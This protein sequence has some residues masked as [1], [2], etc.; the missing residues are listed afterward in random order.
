TGSLPDTADPERDPERLSRLLCG[1]RHLA[2]QFYGLPF[3]EVRDLADELYA[4]AGTAAP[5]SPAGAKA[6]AAATDIYELTMPARM[7]RPGSIWPLG[8]LAEFDG[9]AGSRGISREAAVAWLT[10]G[11]LASLRQ[12]AD[13]QGLDFGAAMAAAIREHAQQCLSAHGPAGTGLAPGRRPVPVLA[14]PPAA[15]PF[16]PAATHQGVVTAPGDAEWLLIRTTA[17][18]EHARQHGYRASDRDADDRIALTEALARACG[19][20]EADVTGRLAPGVAARVTE[21]EHGPAD[22]ARLGREHGQAG[23]VPYCDLDIDGD[24]AAL[25][26]ALGETEQMTDANHGYRISLVIAYADA[27][28]QAS[29]PAPPAAGS[30][31]RDAARG[32]PPPSTSPRSGTR[33]SP[34]AAG[35]ATAHPLHGPERRHGRST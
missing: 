19:L 34:A 4:R 10:A 26:D 20:P 1:V 16:E 13:R 7:R 24:A 6:A 5:G 18:I 33:A 12:Y 2:D 32:F 21:I 11:L 30:P 22:A 23:T 31:A 15:P 9:Y 25:L 3:R 35:P 28:Q 8:T 27:Y 29:R 17:R 14:R